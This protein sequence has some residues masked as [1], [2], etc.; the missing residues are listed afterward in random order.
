[1]IALG[2]PVD[3]AD[4]QR[5][6]LCL[7]GTYTGT[8]ISRAQGFRLSPGDL[9]EAIQVLLRYDYAGR[10][11]EGGALDTG[12]ERVSVFRNG[13]LNGVESCELS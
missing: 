11:A 10:D 4:A 5:E 8:L 3:G 1:M 2:R 13:A 9:D 7:T 6:L 12:F